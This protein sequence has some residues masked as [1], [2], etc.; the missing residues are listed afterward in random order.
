MVVMDPYMPLTHTQRLI[1]HGHCTPCGKARA[2]YYLYRGGNAR[3]AARG[4][5]L[6]CGHR[7][8]RAAGG[9]TARPAPTAAGAGH[10][11]LEAVAQPESSLMAAW[12]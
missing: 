4:E 12:R 11:L 5:G 2:G 3:E 9:R 7:S 8:A 1:W 10:S 6:G